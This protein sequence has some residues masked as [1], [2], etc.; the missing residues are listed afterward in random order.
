MTVFNAL[1]EY[2]TLLKQKRNSHHI[3][4]FLESNFLSRT[5][6]NFLL[7]LEK[8]LHSSLES[9]TGISVS[10]PFNTRY[11]MSEKKAL[12]LLVSLIG[13]GLYSTVAVSTNGSS[14]F[15]TEKGCKAK[16]HSS[17]VYRKQ[18]AEDRGGGHPAL[19]EELKLIA[20]QELVSAS[21]SSIG[22]SLNMIS[23]CPVSVYSYLLACGS[24]DIIPDDASDSDGDGEEEKG[25]SEEVGGERMQHILVDGWLSMRVHDQT[26]AL[27][28]TS[29]SSLQDAL[30]SFLENPKR[31]LA[32]DRLCRLTAITDALVLESPLTQS[33]SS[34]SSSSYEA[35]QG[36]TGGQER[37]PVTQRR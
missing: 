35:S 4:Q 20:Y 26:L 34:N 27:V 9:S 33:S 12:P 18:P 36:A 13:I 7:D 23:N 1:T 31:R 2:D 21:P 25:K 37:K 30:N 15:T 17:S 3:Q 14:K 10:S 5:T 24:I 19:R 29:R 6:M 22:A 32:T 8:Q 28:M 16:V 11:E